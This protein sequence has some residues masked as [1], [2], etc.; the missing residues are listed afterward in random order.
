MHASERS[1]PVAV[2]GHKMV[3]N[4]NSCQR[5]IQI[6]AS[7]SIALIKQ[8]SS[9]FPDGRGAAIASARAGATIIGR[10]NDR[11]R[12]HRRHLQQL[13]LQRSVEIDIGV[14]ALQ[15]LQG[16]TATLRHHQTG[17]VPD[18][19]CNTRAAIR[20]SRPA[21]GSGRRRK[22]SQQCQD[23]QCLCA[24]SCFLAPSLG[25]VPYPCP[26]ALPLGLVPWPC[27]WPLSA[28][29]PASAADI[30]AEG[31]TR[32]G[33]LAAS[34]LS[35]RRDQSSV[36]AKHAVGKCNQ[37]LIGCGTRRCPTQ[38]VD[39]MVIVLRRVEHQSGDECGRPASVICPSSNGEEAA[40]DTARHARS[41]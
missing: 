3:L 9:R 41:R 20:S 32:H 8:A 14:G 36:A 12:D 16:L 34:D 33:I 15:P 40:P 1:S 13:A 22:Y 11:G 5:P 28:V 35:D 6:S 25:L 29:L 39:D 19:F 24:F 27:P 10:G 18:G 17:L 30:E 4:R 26:L 2:D 21:Q 7:A 37:A 31:F 38:S 23:A